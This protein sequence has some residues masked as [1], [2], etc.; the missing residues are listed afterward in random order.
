MSESA[1]VLH[2]VSDPSARRQDPL[3]LERLGPYTIL[4]PLG[5]GAMARVYLAEQRTPI[6]R[7]V[8]IKVLRPTSTLHKA[9]Q[10]MNAERQALARMNHPNIAKVFDAGETDDGR[11]FVV[12]EYVP[13]TPITEFCDRHRLDL[14]TRL[15]LFVQV[16]DGIHH[17]HQQGVLHRD[18]K[19]SNVLVSL[20]RHRPIPKII[21]FGIAK[22]LDGSLTDHTM[23][24]GAV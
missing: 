9:A 19:P 5:G 17:A 3:T 24:T 10:R 18:I 1:S 23:A 12:M 16:C 2:A 11:A 4:E 7:Q 14:D 6:R 20:M 8:A 13:G 21:D 15:R 22:G